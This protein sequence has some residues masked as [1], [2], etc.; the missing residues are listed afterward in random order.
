MG[1]RQRKYK[2]MAFEV[3]VRNPE[4][5]TSILQI[6]KAHEGRKLDKDV[7]FE[8]VFQL[9]EEGIISPK[10]LATDATDEEIKEH[11]KNRM[12]HKADGGFP[13]GY[14][15]RFWCYVRTLSELGFVY[16]RYKEKLQL[17]DV[18]KMLLGGELSE[19]E[20]FAMQIVKYN[21]YNPYRR[22]I[23]DFNYFKFIFH[24][25]EQLDKENKKLSLV[26]YAVSLFSKTNRP[27]S[28]LKLLKDKKFGNKKDFAY[29]YLK[30]ECEK[31]DRCE[32]IPQKQTVFNDYANAV[33]RVMKLAGMISLTNEG[34]IC[35]GL[36]DY[37][38]EMFSKLFAID[39]KLSKNEKEN[40]MSYFDKVGANNLEMYQVIVDNRQRSTGVD[41]TYGSK[42]KGIYTKYFSSRTNSLR[43]CVL[44]MKLLKEDEFA[45]IPDSLKLELLISLYLQ[46][47]YPDAIIKPN[48][49]ADQY[50]MPYSH[51][52]G[53]VG[54]ID[55][56]YE[57]KNWLVEVS[58]IK[59]KEQQINSE[60]INLFRHLAEFNDEQYL[61]LVVPY[62][63]TDT[64]RMINVATLVLM[65]EKE[66]NNLYSS[67]YAFEEFLD[68]TCRK[69]NYDDMKKKT[70]DFLE[71][72]KKIIEKID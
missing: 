30:K 34:I 35:I 11:I 14:T 56:S 22:V 24:A 52:P 4:R 12:S 53:N 21:R 5:Y 36:N 18:A 62:V 55:V 26:Q 51:A 40:A 50:G 10:D 48:Y 42:L 71:G 19:N 61:S 58:M 60:T 6:L 1:Q 32:K 43:D 49:K 17:S 67:A 8:I 45:H 70:K 46:E 28:F 68:I 44:N 69:Q 16:A 27:K 47:Y 13:E 33:L 31:D 38:R 72:T 37:N 59:N 66:K 63:H 41:D 29:Q 57:G 3:A 23:N 7:V 2:M 15:A 25:L 64:K 20:A 39:F 65:L 9:C 54:D